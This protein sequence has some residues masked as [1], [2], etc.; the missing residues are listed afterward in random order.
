MTSDKI[1]DSFEE[2]EI[3][4]VPDLPHF[5]VTKSSKSRID[6][7]SL[8][9][10][11]DKIL[12]GKT[13]RVYWYIL[14]HRRAGVRE[15]QKALKFSSPGTASYQIKKLSNA[16]IISKDNKTDKYFVN[17]D[18]KKGVFGFYVR[19]GFLMI[20]RFSLYLSINILGFIGFIFFASTYGDTFITN[21]GSILLLIFLIFGT[22]VF[23]YESIKLW[24]RNPSKLN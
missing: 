8:E 15:I 24:K 22:A 21:P 2:F 1:K 17:K 18:F 19:I 20:P 6:T 14:T 9:S 10:E 3:E 11:K 12:Q 7:K 13:L 23:I 16:G 5:L 4:L